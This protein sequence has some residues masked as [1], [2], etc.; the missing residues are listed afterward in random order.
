MRCFEH[1][2]LV[3][4]KMARPV[5][6]PASGVV[7]KKDVPRAH[8]RQMIL[9]NLPHALLL[10]AFAGPAASRAAEARDSSIRPERLTELPLEQLMDIEVTTVSRSPQKV[11]Q[12]AAAVY[13]VTQEDIR[14]SGATSIAEALRMAPGVNVARIGSSSWAIS[15]R[16]F[17]DFFANK[18]LVLMD[19]RS[20]YSPLFS[21]VFWDVQD[22][23]LEDIDRIEVIRGPGASLWGANAVNGVINV[24]TKS[25]AETQGGLISGGGGTEEIGSGG[26]RYGGKL[27][28]NAYYRVYAKYFNRDDFVDAA[29]RDAFD[30]WEMWR[31]GFKADWQISDSDSLTVQ[32][33]YY[34]GNMGQRLFA[35]PPPTFFRALEGRALVAG[36]NLLG[37]W[38]HS[39]SES[40]DLALQLYFD[41]TERD[42]RI[43]REIRNTYDVDFQ[44]RLSAGPRQEVLWGLGY[45]LSADE[46]RDGRDR[47][48]SVL[49]RP[50]ER[51]DQLFSAFLQ[52]EITLVEDRLRLTLGSKFEHNDYSG[53]EVQPSSRLLWTPHDKHTFWAAVSRAVR[54]PARWEHSIEVW[55]AP[56]PAAGP[57]PFPLLLVGNEDFESEN[58]IAYEVGY[59]I[60]PTPK[61]SVDLATFYNRYDD[62]LVGQP[63]GFAPRLPPPFPPI[64]LAHPQNGMDGETYGAEA[65]LNWS[66]S[67]S[68]RLNFGYSFLQMQL[69][70]NVPGSEIAE[71]DSPHHQVHLRSYLDLPYHLQLD[72]ALNYVDN[73]PNRGVPN[74]VR[75]DARIGWRP[76]N[77]LELSV[78]VQNILDDRHPEFGPG[79]L[80]TPTEVQRSVYAKM[81]WQF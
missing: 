55:Y 76:S 7:N 63:F 36:G 38:K 50:A 33:D 16:G 9:K 60:Q 40:S 25:A 61:T 43:H 70:S 46:L 59:R 54:S 23:M 12:S 80:V 44:H 3:T 27:G 62:L 24:I 11:S 6:K 41:R 42:D 2:C 17:N 34:D 79:F 48:G 18:L 4:I 35:F 52:D 57:P 21:G 78:G 65:S 37:S 74:Y 73:L 66:L 20:V 64:P 68:W 31:G 47:S 69:H 71:G 26:I 15:A 67:D 8:P 45:R 56:P 32:G 58:L 5:T 72:A 53:S 19:G 13:V 39:V 81:T 14:R 28:R 30:E 29:G 51:N 77:A 22:T 1:D 75:L 49:F 10:A